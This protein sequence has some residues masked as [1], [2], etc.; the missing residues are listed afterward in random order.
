MYD[1]VYAY[2]SDL[3]DQVDRWNSESVVLQENLE[4]LEDLAKQQAKQVKERNQVLY[5]VERVLRTLPPKYPFLSDLMKA[6]GSGN[7]TYWNEVFQRVRPALECATVK[8]E[9][10]LDDQGLEPTPEPGTHL[11]LV[12]LTES[13]YEIFDSCQKLIQ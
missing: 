2:A 5:E 10:K 8:L 3:T 1:V 9:N 13:V 4:K 11:M 12:Y 6:G 7:H